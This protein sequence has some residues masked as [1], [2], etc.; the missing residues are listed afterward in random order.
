MARPS[1]AL[2]RFLTVLE[3]K[4]MSALCEKTIR[5]AI[6]NGDLRAHRIGRAVRISEEDYIAFVASRRR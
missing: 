3:V 2:P 1:K 5:R 4:E 6:K